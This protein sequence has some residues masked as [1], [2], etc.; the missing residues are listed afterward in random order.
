MR[1]ASSKAEKDDLRPEYDLTKLKKAVRG[2]YY[3]HAMAGTN[4]V[5]VD[6]DLAK[7]FPDSASV[8]RALRVLCNA[9][10]KST[11]PSRRSSKGSIHRKRSAA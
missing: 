2:K 4:L 7:V 1:K 6:P 3:K 11:Q 10:G 8:N 9:A 5:L